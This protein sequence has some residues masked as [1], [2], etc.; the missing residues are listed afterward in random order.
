MDIN[1]LRCFV[2]VGKELHFGRA[3][4]RMEMMPAS[5]SRFIRLLEEDLG[6]R[7]LNRSTRNVSLT[8]EGA[9]FFDEASKLIDQFDALTIRFK[10]GL[11]N[12]RRTLRIGAIDTAAHGLV[13]ALLNMFVPLHPNC[14]IHIIEDKTINLIPKLKSGWLDMIFF[15]APQVIDAS[16]NVRF[17]TRESCV[18][19]VP[20]HHALAG[21]G[22]VSVDD[23]KN[24]A[25]I[26]PDRRTRP[27]SHE[28]TMSIFKYS[29][30]SP[31]VAQFAEEKQ[32]ILSLVAAGLGLA[33]VPS[34]YRNI[35]S[36][37]VSYIELTLDESIKGLPL[38]IAWQKGNEDDY[39]REMLKLLNDNKRELTEK[40]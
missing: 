31:H 19:A 23:I 17:I 3:A 39:L 29:G 37:N 6:V 16:I 11:K 12:E 24:E 26:I 5:L 22:R 30:L 33:V 9:I 35:N 36:E 18:L 13:P 10:G 27:H 4:Q 32:T 15:R 28:L 34:S 1:Q 38:S 8:S 2:A 21:R 25:M 7:L 14:D 20:M 40:L